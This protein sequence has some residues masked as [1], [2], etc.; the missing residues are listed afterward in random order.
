MS[1]VV[2]HTNTHIEAVS[3][4]QRLWEGAPRTEDDLVVVI[5][6]KIDNLHT[7]TLILDFDKA[8]QIHSQLDQI[9]K[10]APLLIEKQIQLKTVVEL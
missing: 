3:L 10:A 6:L 2:E 1:Y 5:H 7:T 9:M 4:M 8:K